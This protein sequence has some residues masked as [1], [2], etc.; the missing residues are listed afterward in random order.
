[1]GNNLD[2]SLGITWQY[3]SFKMLGVWF[4]SD[5]KQVIA[6]NLDEKLQKIKNIM[7]LWSCQNL[8][9][10]EKVAILNT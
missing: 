4:N 2:Q 1:M 3:G 5:E 6:M 9:I 8:T 7:K 10:H